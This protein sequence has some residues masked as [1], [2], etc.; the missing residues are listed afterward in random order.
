MVTMKPARAGRV[1]RATDRVF[2][3]RTRGQQPTYFAVHD[4]ARFT[5]SSFTMLMAF[6]RESDASIW[7]RSLDV[8]RE[9]RGAYPS[10]EMAR[11]TKRLAW[12]QDDA[13]PAAP[14]LDVVSMPFTDVVAMLTGTGVNCRLLHDGE[15]MLHRTDVMQPFDRAAACSRL[16]H[17]LSLA[18][19]DEKSEK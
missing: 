13:C 5:R 1:I 19:E 16:E 12:V 10:R 7:A 2:L 6:A 15:N 4:T 3:I 18:C 11:Q 8:Y 17:V 9:E 14:E